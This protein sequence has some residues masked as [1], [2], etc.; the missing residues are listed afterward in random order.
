MTASPETLKNRVLAR[1]KAARREVD[2]RAGASRPKVKRGQPRPANPE[3][4]VTEETLDS[5]SLKRVFRQLGVSYRRYRKET[6][7]P[8]VPAIRDA[9]I[10]FRAEPSLASLVTLAGYLDELELLD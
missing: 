8:V 10:S 6:G 2:Q 3:S 5:E 1:V 9:A 7:D 4:P